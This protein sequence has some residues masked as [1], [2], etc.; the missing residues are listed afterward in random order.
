MENKIQK[1][2]KK[3]SKQIKLLQVPDTVLPNSI[4]KFY[5]HN[6]YRSVE[7]FNKIS[8]QFL[9]SVDYISEHFWS[10][11]SKNTQ[12]TKMLEFSRRLDSLL[13][14]ASK[15]EELADFGEALL[16]YKEFVNVSKEIIHKPCDSDALKDE[17]MQ[18]TMKCI[19]RGTA[20]K[21]VIHT[22]NLQKAIGES[23][24]QKDKAKEIQKIE[25]DEALTQYFAS[26]KAQR[27]TQNQKEK[28][29]K[30]SKLIWISK[31]DVQ[32]A[33]IVGSKEAKDCVKD[34]I[35]NSL[36]RADLLLRKPKGILLYGKVIL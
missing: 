5:H 30:M 13:E 8:N 28:V 22:Q 4:V 20:V 24:G 34:A 18:L 25:I 11:I 10:V 26:D 2:E 36:Y 14:H 7:D 27:W 12:K 21:N 1:E 32:F 16:V 35:C 9:E 23:Q 15:Q 33:D 3:L 6:E 31:S 29:V 19:E 17:V